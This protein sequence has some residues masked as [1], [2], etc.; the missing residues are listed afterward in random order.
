MVATTTASSNLLSQL[1]RDF[2]TLRFEKSDDF[3]WSSSQ[4]TVFYADINPK[5][6]VVLLHETAHGVLEHSGYAYDIDLLKLERDAW[7]KAK[8][9]GQKYKI[10]I[11]DNTV[12]EA[13]D[14]YRDWLHARSLC[15]NC[16]QNGLQTGAAI[17][18]CVICS[19]SWRVNEARVCGLRRRFITK[20]TPV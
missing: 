19:Q 1:R 9:I 5:N 16:R 12:E 7:E 13:L 11:D 17:Y 2:P 14:S 10:S 6:Q 18:S 4:K 20:T 15:P 8:D 3:K